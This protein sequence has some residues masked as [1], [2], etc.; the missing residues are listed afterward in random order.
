MKIGSKIHSSTARKRSAKTAVRRLNGVETWRQTLDRLIWMLLRAGVDPREIT[1]DTAR[2]LKA[3]H[4]LRTLR[5]PPPEVLEYA[6]VLTYWRNEPQFLDEQGT[7]RSLPLTGGASS[8]RAL[9][10]KA[11][12]GVSRDDVLAVLR[13][14]QL[15]SVDR[16]QRVTLRASSFV[17]RNEQRAQ[18]FAYTLSA[19]EG[20]ID[21]CHRNLTARK[22]ADSIGRLQRVASA[23]RFDLRFIRDYDAFLRDQATDFLLRQDAWLKRHEA[24]SP[25]AGTRMAQ[26]GVGIFGFRA[27]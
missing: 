18:F 26:V 23:E 15:V 20:I 12:P 22:P 7:P 5:I 19:V 10:R 21:T 13:R 3:H 11:L 4:G 8:F 16:N 9:L 6:R 24:K 27:R 25:R 1:S 17:P 14:H 2:I